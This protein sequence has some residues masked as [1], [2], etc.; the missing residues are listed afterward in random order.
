MKESDLK[1]LA[2]MYFKKKLFL[3]DS[4]TG[5]ITNNPT[6]KHTDNSDSD[7]EISDN[8][9]QEIATDNVDEDSEQSILA[10]DQA[11]KI[12]SNFPI[13][14]S[15]YSPTR[16][17]LPKQSIFEPIHEVDKVINSLLFSTKLSFF[18]T[19]LAQSATEIINEVSND[20][21][22]YINILRGNQI[23]L[24]DDKISQLKTKKAYLTSNDLTEN[25]KRIRYIRQ[26]EME[27]K[28]N[29]LT[30]IILFYAE[31]VMGDTTP[32]SIKKVESWLKNKIKG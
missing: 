31:Y 14:K 9:S 4:D 18:D 28:E 5:S 20:S 27:T 6:E 30:A 10:V 16:Q 21:F 7:I 13:D 15:M 11:H 19:S 2:Q 29:Y 1:H 12:L 23:K 22:G 24:L 3:S 17:H 25:L 8:S 26:T 32:E